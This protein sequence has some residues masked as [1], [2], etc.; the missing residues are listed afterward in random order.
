MQMVAMMESSGL[1]WRGSQKT[2]ME[3]D[4]DFRFSEAEDPTEEEEEEMR[5]QQQAMMEEMLDVLEDELQ[6][7]Q[8][9]QEQLSHLEKLD[10]LKAI[11]NQDRFK[12]DKAL[13]YLW[14]ASGAPI[15]I[16]RQLT[17]QD[18]K[19]YHCITRI[20]LQR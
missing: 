11:L 14:E 17:D 4:N 7:Q 8:E 3:V 18:G 16:Y 20:K 15:F 1:D 12:P 19:R 6:R 9:Q 2:P 13:P 10:K 5:R